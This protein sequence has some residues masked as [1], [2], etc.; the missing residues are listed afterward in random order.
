MVHVWTA[1]G[2]EF[3]RFESK[4]GRIF[5]APKPF[6]LVYFGRTLKQVQPDEQG[7]FEYVSVRLVPEQP[8]CL[9]A[10]PS[11]MRSKSLAMMTNGAVIAGDW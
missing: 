11:Q 9:G 4:V 6:D 3:S 10:L 8:R 2:G 1:C 7:G 5:G